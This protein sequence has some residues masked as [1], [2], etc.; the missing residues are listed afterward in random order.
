MHQF[1]Y[2]YLQAQLHS[3]SSLSSMLSLTYAFEFV[4][5]QRTFQH[6]QMFSKIFSAKL[7]LEPSVYLLWTNYLCLKWKE[8]FPSTATH[9]AMCCFSTCEPLRWELHRLYYAGYREVLP[10]WTLA[11]WPQVFSSKNGSSVKIFCVL[12]KC[13]MSW[14]LLIFT[15]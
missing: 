2:S 9:T 11:I 3:N 14:I 10:C 5:F 6:W 7:P 15:V 1:L 12:R 8:T 13:K 4:S